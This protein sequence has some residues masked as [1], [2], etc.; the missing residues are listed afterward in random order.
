MFFLLRFFEHSVDSLPGRATP[1]EHFVMADVLCLKSLHRPAE[2]VHSVLDHH[3]A[4]VPQCMLVHLLQLGLLLDLTV[5]QRGRHSLMVGP[6]NRAK[7]PNGNTHLLGVVVTCSAPAMTDL[8]SNHCVSS[9]L[10][11]AKV[12]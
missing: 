1:D 2:V 4:I 7:S 5:V 9:R 10:T 8:C 11:L 3:S 6:H 12:A